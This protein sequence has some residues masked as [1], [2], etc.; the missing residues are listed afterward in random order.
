MEFGKHV[1]VNPLEPPDSHY[2]RAAEGWLE[3]GH[4]GEANQELR[5]ITPQLLSHPDVLEVRWQV[6][7]RAMEWNACAEIGKA[8]VELASDR[9]TGWLH[10]AYGLRRA[11]G[12]GLQVAWDAL[13]PAAARFPDVH[14]VPF[15]LACYAAQMGRL[16]EAHDWLK[17]AFEIAEKAGKLNLVRLRA[18]ADPDLEPLWR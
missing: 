6:Y 7:A 1:P 11:T 13:F 10:R 12:G 14:V 8:L 16:P 4:I 9:V 18:L 15:N 3:L 5:K 17:Q 2:L